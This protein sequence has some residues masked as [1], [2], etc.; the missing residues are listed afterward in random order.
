MH[1][2][3]TS[4]L[5]EY[6]ICGDGMINCDLDWI[7]KYFRQCWDTPLGFQTGLMNVGDTIQW[8]GVLDCIRRGKGR[9]HLGRALLQLPD[10]LRCDKQPHV[11]TATAG[12]GA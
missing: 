2:A 8:A 1:I 5:C 7:K 12:A 11:S 9:W 10:L 6:V 4:S 3:V